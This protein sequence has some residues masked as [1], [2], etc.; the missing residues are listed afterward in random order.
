M[1]R[2]QP[3]PDWD[4]SI[5]LRKWVDVLIRYRFLILGIVVVVVGVA[6]AFGYLVQTPRFESTAGA[7]V[8][9]ANGEGGLGLTL[10]GYQEF[11]T[12]TAVIESMRQKLGEDSFQSGGL[13]NRYA[14]PFSG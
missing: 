13:V 12:S 11:A 8:P 10:R 1:T 14:G 5:N 3:R 7:V 9:S 6:A 2:P 4:D